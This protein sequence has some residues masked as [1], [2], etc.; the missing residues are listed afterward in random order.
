MQGQT[1]LIEQFQGSVEQVAQIERQMLPLIM[2]MEG[3]LSDFIDIDLPF[4][5][6]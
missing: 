5:E 4:H 3:A 1:A 6:T 2:R